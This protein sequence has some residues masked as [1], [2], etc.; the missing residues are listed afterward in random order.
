VP[1]EIIGM[2]EAPG[3]GG[4]SRQRRGGV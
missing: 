4:D 3:A 1:V 2:G